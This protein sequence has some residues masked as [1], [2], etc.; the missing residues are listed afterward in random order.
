MQTWPGQARGLVALVTYALPRQPPTAPARGPEA[1]LGL[2]PASLAS[3]VDVQGLPRAP[4]A[5]GAMASLLSVPFVGRRHS[6]AG[7]PNCPF[8]TSADLVSW[9]TPV[10]PT[11]PLSRIPD[12]HGTA[13]GSPDSPQDPHPPPCAQA[14][15][16]PPRAP[17]W[18]RAGFESAHIP[19]RCLSSRHVDS[20]RWPGS[21][22]TRHAGVCTGMGTAA[23][24]AQ[25]AGQG[26]RRGGRPARGGHSR[27]P[28]GQAFHA[29]LGLG[30]GAT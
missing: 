19:P 27:S 12:L 13:G 11:R 3:G 29:G 2:L 17:G 7:T 18:G 8:P 1:G 28:A 30:A 20:Q 5:L 23:V 25:G 24:E 9:K 14:Q 26:A 15:L 21:S 6:A 10:A 16:S 4:A 22:R